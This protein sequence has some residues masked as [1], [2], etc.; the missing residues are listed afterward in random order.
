MYA[1]VNLIYKLTWRTD[2]H[3]YGF[4]KFTPFSTMTNTKGVE[5]MIYS[6]NVFCFE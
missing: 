4:N 3:I 6:S 5:Q 1:C 2:S